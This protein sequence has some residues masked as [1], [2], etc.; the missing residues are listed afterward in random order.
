MIS[1]TTSFEPEF[2]LSGEMPG[3]GSWL[4]K[5]LMGRY[6]SLRM[7]LVYVLT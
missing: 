7:N 3:L 5:L 1:G 4:C 2:D 6:I